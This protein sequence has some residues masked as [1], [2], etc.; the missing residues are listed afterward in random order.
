MNVELPEWVYN[1]AASDL[2][3]RESLRTLSQY[4]LVTPETD[5]DGFSIHPVVHIWSLHNIETKECR[6]QISVYA[7]CIV[8]EFASALSTD[9]S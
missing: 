4:S 9:N 7:L 3:F 5:L 8:A 1:L 6:E 2:S